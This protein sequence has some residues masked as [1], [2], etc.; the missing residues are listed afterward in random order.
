MLSH[1]TEVKLTL[2]HAANFSSESSCS[3]ETS[4]TPESFQRDSGVSRN[5]LYS[6]DVIVEVLLQDSPRFPLLGSFSPPRGSDRH[7]W[8]TP[9]QNVTADPPFISQANTNINKDIESSSG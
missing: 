8:S 9:P 3:T 4:E 7:L 2:S 1:F 6:P 5:S